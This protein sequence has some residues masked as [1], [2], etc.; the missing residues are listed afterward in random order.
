VRAALRMPSREPAHPARFEPKFSPPTGTEI[1]I[2]VRWKD[3]KGKLQAV[4]AQ[5][6][7][8]NIETKKPLDTN[9]VFAGSMFVTR[10]DNGER[11]Y[12]A[13]SGDMICVLSSPIAMLDLPMF[14]YGALEARTFEVFKEHM[15]PQGTP[16]T[17]LLK[18]ILSRN[19]SNKG[20]KTPAGAQEKHADAEQKAIAA[21]EAWLA[22]VD[23]GEY[24]K[25]WET[26][27]ERLKSTVPRRDFIKSVGDLRKLLGKLA[28]RQLNTQEYTTSL[29]DAP[30]GQY[31]VLQYKASFANKKAATEMV[32]P[33]LDKD[34][35][36]RVSG[37]YV[38]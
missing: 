28:A 31:V 38:K 37:Y 15:P 23:R 13:N 1:A 29:R 12:A 27:S 14:G 30:A 35:K 7:I 4:P 11:Y 18:P 22:L 19:P 6:W 5:Q 26:G 24:S 9:W 17:M 21:A 25:A 10:E 2:E 36:W 33:M 8:R 34:K 16:I 32:V 3:A 20:P